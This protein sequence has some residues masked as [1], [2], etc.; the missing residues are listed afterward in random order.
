MTRVLAGPFA[1]MMLADLGARVIKV[2]RPGVGDDSRKYGPFQDE[3]SAYFARVNRGKESIAL[4][5]RD[6]A[7]RHVLLELIK[8]ADILVENFRPGVMDRLGLGWADLSVL[9]P[10][11]VYCSVSG[12]GH[13]GPWSTRPAYD[14]VVQGLSGLMSI[15]GTPE[16]GPTKPGIPVS[17]LAG[18]VF[19]FGGI[20][21]AIHQRHRTGF[22]DRVDVAMYDATIALLE[23]AALQSISKGANVERIGNA[24]FSIAPFDTFKADD[25]LIVICAAHDG[26]FENLCAALSRP[27]WLSDPRWATNESRHSRRVELTALINEALVGR[28]RAEW[29]LILDEAGVPCAEVSEVLDALHSEQT[30][31]RQMLVDADGMTLPGNP[32]KLSS[33]PSSAS[34]A[35]EPLVDEQGD[36]IRAWLLADS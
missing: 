32:M 29:L 6:E 33:F 15:T 12:F 26:L 8:R 23:S 35:R 31:A 4:D 36:A 13:T 28:S 22:G 19:G 30:V 20:M 11:L 10:R 17:D 18:G 9:N 1:A 7:D 34:I 27:E 14:S 21:A 3:R 25:G 24:H 5:L 16:S 2:E